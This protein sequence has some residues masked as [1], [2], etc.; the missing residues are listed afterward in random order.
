MLFLSYTIRP[1][2]CGRAFHSKYFFSVPA[3]NTLRTEPETKTVRLPF[4]VP[5]IPFPHFSFFIA[6]NRALK[7]L[8][9]ENVLG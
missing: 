6:L 8:T 3:L 1:L 7:L 2:V 9:D 5:P 4:S